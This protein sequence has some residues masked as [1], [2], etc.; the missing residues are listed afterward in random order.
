MKNDAYHKIGLLARVA[1]TYPF[2]LAVTMI[3][4]LVTVGVPEYASDRRASADGAKRPLSAA[5][6]R[7]RLFAIPNKVRWLPDG[8]LHLMGLTREKN[9]REVLDKNGGLVWEGRRD[10]EDFPYKHLVFSSPPLP[11]SGTMVSPALFRSLNGIEPFGMAGDI[12]IQNPDEKT[13]RLETWRYDCAA[14]VFHRYDARGR[15]GG[16]L[17]ANGFVETMQQALAFGPFR[18]G[19]RGMSPKHLAY[20]ITERQIHGLNLTKR[21]AVP[22]LPGDSPIISLDH[23]GNGVGLHAA[24]EDGMHYFIN[25]NAKTKTPEVRSLP[26]RDARGNQI[27]GRMARDGKKGPLYL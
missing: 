23:G 17:G 6:Q 16:S 3:T 19:V 21:S 18:M 10:A 5:A 20:W 15:Y 26:I 25:Y 14:E 2:I 24:T 9:R 12:P 1:F 8:T 11:R 22:L 13:V 7:S 4:L 27:N